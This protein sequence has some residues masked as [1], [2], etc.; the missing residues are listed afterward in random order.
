MLTQA[1]AH[2]SPPGNSRS[3]SEDST[4]CRAHIQALERSA[5]GAEVECE[6]AVKQ[7][8]DTAVQQVAVWRAAAQAIA[9]LQAAQ[10]QKAATAAKHSQKVTAPGLTTCCL[11]LAPERP[12]ASSCSIA[13]VSKQLA[14]PK[15]CLSTAL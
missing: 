13:A 14:V 6:A 12:H 7:R 4:R 8:V 11:L 3:C 5:R 15:I 2:V 10:E 9:K 1:Q